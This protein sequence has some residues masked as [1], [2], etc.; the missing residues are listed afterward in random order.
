MLFV[1][2]QGASE[3]QAE[4]EFALPE[5]I[6]R[7]LL[8]FARETIGNLIHGKPEPQLDAS[9]PMLRQKAAVFV[10]LHKN[11]KL[12]GCIGTTEPHL[13][14]LEAVRTYASAAAFEDP[15]FDSVTAN[16]LPELKIEI[17]VLSPMRQITSVEE[18]I[19]FKHGV[20]VT[21]G[22]HRG[23]FLPQVWE[24]LPDKEMF[25]NYLCAE[26]AG[27]SFDAWR[28]PRTSIEIFTVFAFEEPLK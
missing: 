28:S 11:G 2:T 1:K 21:Q 26:K 9:D 20:M 16:E 15:R 7:K 10:T 25:L 14:L 18:I 19:P 6:Q 5:P 23:L 24:Q 4:K 3:R 12:R 22:F 8:T 27:L 17:S 13:P